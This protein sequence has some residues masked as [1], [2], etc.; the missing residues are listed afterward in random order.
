MN[1]KA[2]TAVFIL[3]AT[4]FNLLLMGI[5]LIASFVVASSLFGDS[6]SPLAGLIGFLIIGVTDRNHLLRLRSGDAFGTETLEPGP[7]PAPHLPPPPIRSAT[8]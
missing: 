5:L 1:K 8:P 6:S 7:V 2:N 4:V 3:V